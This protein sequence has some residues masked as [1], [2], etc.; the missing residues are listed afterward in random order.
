VIR[1]SDPD[2]SSSLHRLEIV[3]CPRGLACRWL[4]VAEEDERRLE[5]VQADS[6]AGFTT[7]RIVLRDTRSETM[8][9]LPLVSATSARVSE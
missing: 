1:S 3:E 9:E 4:P 8:V 7:G 5:I 2:D 6:E